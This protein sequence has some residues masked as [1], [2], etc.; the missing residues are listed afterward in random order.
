M[1]HLSTFKQTQMEEAFKA[2][3]R[4]FANGVSTDI[5]PLLATQRIFPM[6]Y[7]NEML[8]KSPG[9]YI[10]SQRSSGKSNLFSLNVPI[11][12]FFKWRYA[13]PRPVAKARQGLWLVHWRSRTLIGWRQDQGTSGVDAPARGA[14]V[15]KPRCARDARACWERVGATIKGIPWWKMWKSMA[16][17]VV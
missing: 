11:Y 3:K 17:L 2:S 9:K 10:N 13:I 8:D 14:A 4:R 5:P 16:W 1:A 12:A 7:V 15:L 6:L